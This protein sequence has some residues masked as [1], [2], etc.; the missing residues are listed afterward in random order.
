MKVDIF[1]LISVAPNGIGNKENGL[2]DLLYSYLLCE[3]GLDYYKYIKVNQIGADQGIEEFVDIRKGF[4]HINIIF[5][6]DLNFDKLNDIT[7]NK[8]RLDIIHA[9][10]L[11]LGDKDPKFS[12]I[13]LEKIKKEILERD[14]NFELEGKI[15]KNRFD[16][17]TS[18][19]LLIN[20]QTKYFDYFFL[21]QKDGKNLCRIPIYR[22]KPS[23]YYLDSFFSTLTWNNESQLT[24][25]GKEKQMKIILDTTSCKLT[26][27]NL[28]KYPKPPLWEMMRAD[29]DEQQ[30]SNAYENWL[31][32][33]P[34]GYS[35]IIR[36]NDN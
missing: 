11:R 20:P 25:T 9:G 14:F 27:Q 23:T 18:F 34:P 29:I 22:G 12:K 19:K 31:D 33:L 1:R 21:I 35:A 24:V 10:L 30:S 4:V 26:F 32:S 17:I 15:R 36:D 13:T 2:L 8:L 16:D 28:T 3:N 6:T 7:K 5:N